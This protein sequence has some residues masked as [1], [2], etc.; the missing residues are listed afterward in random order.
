MKSEDRQPIANH[1][2]PTFGEFLRVS[3]VAYVIMSFVG[4]EI[5]WWYH[6]N[7]RAKFGP[8]TYDLVPLLEIIGASFLFLQICQKAMEL[9]SPSYLVFR[10]TLAKFF[11]GVS[12]RGALW[13]ALVSAFGEEILF[14]GA[15]QPILGLWLTSIGFGLVHLDPKGGVSV[16][17]AWAML[18]GLLLGAMVDVTGSL[19]PAIFVHFLVN[20][21]GMLGLSKVKV[22]STIS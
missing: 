14:R 20:F 16:L 21:V 22:K 1:D 9:F 6:K 8:I 12:W 4:I 3:T 18:A 10:S 11:E 17:T 5:C 7:V 13:L 2:S 19:W 15:L